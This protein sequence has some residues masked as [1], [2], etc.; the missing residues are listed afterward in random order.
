MC[1]DNTYNEVGEATKVEYLK[2][3]N[4]SEHSAPVW[5]SETRN[6]SVRGETLS[7]SNTLASE[8]YAYDSVGRLTEAK[9]TPAAEGCSVRLYAYDEES[10]RTSQATRVPGGGG[11]CATEGG[12]VLSHTYDSG[13]R[14][15]DSGVAY[16][17]FGNLTKVPAAD[18]EGHELSSSFY[19]SG[20]V[21]SQT[22]NGVTNNYYLDP[23]GRIRETVNGANATISHYDGSGQTVVW[24][25]ETGGKSTRN[26]P[27]IDGSLAAV[28]TNGGT[29]VLQ[30]H[31]LQGDIAATAALSPSETKVLSTY[32]STE[33]GVP[34]KEKAPPKFAWLGA[35]GVASSLSSGVITYGATSYVPQI[36][37][38]LQSEVVEAPGIAPG[39]T[40]AGAA[41]VS[42]EEPWVFQGAAAEAAEAPGLEAAREEA[43]LRAAL[44]AGDPP[45]YE[46]FH[47]LAA[48]KVGK[49]LDSI[50][51]IGEFLNLFLDLPKE[52]ISFLE[53]SL[54]DEFEHIQE[55]LDW[56][57]ESGKK[58]MKCGYN[59]SVFLRICKLEYDEFKFSAFGVTLEF[60]NPWGMRPIV[61]ECYDLGDNNMD[62]VHTVEIPRPPEG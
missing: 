44:A 37:R 20:A 58:L 27:G 32:N 34:N 29:P 59:K 15:T 54:I 46:T 11:A 26:I 1:A 43:A 2:T 7:R 14:L 18:A 38:A 13:N 28:Q 10:N 36:G 30:L 60:P 61:Q 42:Q 41:Y 31:D 3:T 55:A 12:T 49:E 24:T 40:G 23:E 17:S 48:R 52:A 62:C 56:F 8:S 21:A 6:P 22:Q 5:F 39:G 33:F 47:R 50:G 53:K 16:D 51:T 57:H 25:S 45:T 9:E 19:V 4:C 35:G